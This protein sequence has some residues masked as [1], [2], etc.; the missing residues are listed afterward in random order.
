MT[1]FWS[2]HFI[3]GLGL[4]TIMW[5]TDTNDWNVEPYGP[6]PTA[7]LRETYS[8]IIAQATQPAA[9]NG[10]IIVLEHE[11]EDSAMNMSIEQYPAVKKAWKNVVPLT[12]CLNITN[13]YPEDITYPNFEE[14]VAGNVLP[15]GL[16][17]SDLK[18][19]SSASF[20]P[21]GTLSGQGGTFP[22]ASDGAGNPPGA[23]GSSSN[24]GSSNQGSTQQN[25]KSSGANAV[26][27]LP[28][29]FVMLSMSLGGMFGALF[30]LF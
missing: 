5:N 18:I 30:V 1:D 3:L 11:L 16:P 21:Q 27:S 19:S 13:P 22:T 25:V 26:Y 10:G 14:Y 29:V 4:R 24:S 28:S 7:S 6:I 9:L 23:Q 2:L 17:S 20:Q 8:S 12:A 15:K